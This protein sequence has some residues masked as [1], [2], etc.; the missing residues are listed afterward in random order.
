MN[1]STYTQ[2]IIRGLPR[3]IYSWKIMNS[4]QNGVPDC[5]FS[6]TKGDIWIECKYIK[7]M[8]KRPSTLINPGLSALQKRW[9]LG[10]YH[11]GRNVAVLIGSPQGS[12]ILTEDNLTS[13]IIQ[14]DLTLTYKEVRQWII[15]QTLG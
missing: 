13:D 4:M 3:E 12:C 5:Y 7:T 6:A 11:E 10:R 9:I 2:S 1:E 15:S 14:S 8:P